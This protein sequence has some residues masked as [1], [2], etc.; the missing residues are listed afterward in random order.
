M[1][2]S[3]MQA[4][5]VAVFQ[6]TGVMKSEKLFSFRV[7]VLTMPP[8]ERE[9]FVTRA[10]WNRMR[11]ALDGVLRRN[12]HAAWT[13]I[14][15]HPVGDE[16]PTQF[17]PHFNVLWGKRGISPGVMP[18]AE[19]ELLKRWWSA[20]LEHG[21]IPRQPRGW[22]KAMKTNAALGYRLPEGPPRRPVNVHGEFTRL[23]QPKQIAHRARYYSRVFV[24]WRSWM[25]KA[26][27][28]YGAFVRGLRP[29]AV[30][31]VCRER[32]RMLGM[33][34]EAA[35]SYVRLLELAQLRGQAPPGAACAASL[36]LFEGHGK[37]PASA[38]L[39]GPPSASVH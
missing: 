10:A 29:V 35:I 1:L 9:R 20:I 16:D 13:M 21:G 7:S 30:C 28:W 27:Q 14:S 25:P 31:P 33:G 17:H 38:T 37:A 19:L 12:F 2:T 32:F 24:G 39:S 4:Q 34:D 15:T 11:A 26:V 36:P 18:A 23:D 22:C 6:Q 3:N 5:R 8:E